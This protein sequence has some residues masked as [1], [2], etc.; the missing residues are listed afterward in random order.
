MKIFPFIL[1][2]FRERSIALPYTGLVA[3]KKG[4]FGSPSRIT[5]GSLNI[6]IYIYI[7]LLIYYLPAFTVTKKKNRQ[8]S[9][10]TIFSNHCLEKK[11]KD[12]REKK[13]KMLTSSHQLKIIKR[14]ANSWSK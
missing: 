7:Y 9:E 3:I 5:F 11:E 14:Y 6:Y 10:I 2:N 8:N 4:A 1:N 13:K 12:Y